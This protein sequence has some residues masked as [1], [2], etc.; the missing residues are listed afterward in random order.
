MGLRSK[1]STLTREEV[2]NI[3]GEIEGHDGI[4]SETQ[5]EQSE[6]SK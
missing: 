1:N 5:N 2:V 4:V 6:V 3:L